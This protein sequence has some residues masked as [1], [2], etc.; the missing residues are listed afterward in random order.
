MRKHLLVIRCNLCI[1][2][3][4]IPLYTLPSIYLF[5]HFHRLN[6]HLEGITSFIIII[7]IPFYHLTLSPVFFPLYEISNHYQIALVSNSWLIMNQIDSPETKHPNLP[8]HLDKPWFREAY[9]AA[10]KFYEKDKVLD[11]HDRLKL[12]NTY[13]DITR[14]QSIAGFLGFLTVFGSP[15]MY[16]YYTTRSIKN[17]KVPRNFLLGLLA[18][19]V[20]SSLASHISYNKQL[21]K[22]DPDGKLSRKNIYP[23][24]DFLEDDPNQIKS[25]NERQFEMLTLLKNGGSARWA[26]YFYITYL[27]P[28]RAFPDPEEKL[29]QLQQN[30]DRQISVSPFMHQKDPM[31]LYTNKR[32]GF[33]NDPETSIKDGITHDEV[34]PS[35]SDV[36]KLWDTNEKQQFNQKHISS[37]DRI[38]TR[39]PSN[40]NQ[41]VN[42]FEDK[43][44]SD[45]LFDDFDYE[46]NQIIS[47]PQETVSQREFNQ[48]LEKERKG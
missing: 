35:D 36:D 28:E 13:K 21:H 30:S 9:I 42:N 24:D 19:F 41:L 3:C 46:N 39:N 20:S 7:I 10:K 33:V 2:L 38:R 29:K 34:F 23:H 8:Q 18:T 48:M 43:S 6:I 27:Y 44:T 32:T 15:F 26:S 37:W 16:K 14:A 25:R 45:D 31:G 1:S 17:V 11:S 22:L 47:Y 4:L 12:Y 40:D 5:I